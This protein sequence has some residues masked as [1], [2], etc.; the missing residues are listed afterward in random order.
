MPFDGRD[1]TPA[2]NRARLIEALRAE[3][4]ADYRWNFA[5]IHRQQSCGTVGCAIGLAIHIGLP[6]KLSPAIDSSLDRSIAATDLAAV[7]GISKIDAFDIFMSTGAYTGCSR[8]QPW[9]ITPA[10]VADALERFT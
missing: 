8:L 7:F 9:K 3:M 4:P 1:S 2:L 6:V 10:M 5:V